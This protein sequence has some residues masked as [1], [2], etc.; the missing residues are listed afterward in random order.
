[1]QIYDFKG[2][3]TSLSLDRLVK[4]SHLRPKFLITLFPHYYFKFKELRFIARFSMKVA[5]AAAQPYVA[6]LY[7]FNN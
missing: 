4:N 3:I 6:T 7:D 2:K 1:M 5:G